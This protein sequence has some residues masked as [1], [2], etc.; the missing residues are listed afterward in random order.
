VIAHPRPLRL[1]VTFDGPRAPI[2][3]N[4]VEALADLARL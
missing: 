4:L 3:E 1:G 2:P